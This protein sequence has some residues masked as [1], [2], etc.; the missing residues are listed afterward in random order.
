MRGYFNQG[1][2]VHK[3][4]QQAVDGQGVSSSIYRVLH[5]P[6]QVFPGRVADLELAWSRVFFQIKKSR[7]LEGNRLVLSWAERFHLFLAMLQS[8]VVFG[9]TITKN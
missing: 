9:I 4:P 3:S 7:L 2:K 6:H 1:A 8:V 5:Q